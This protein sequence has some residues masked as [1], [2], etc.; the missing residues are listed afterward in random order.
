MGIYT[1]A[2]YQ[3]HEGSNLVTE[4]IYDRF[5]FKIKENNDLYDTIGYSQCFGEYLQR[6]VTYEI[7]D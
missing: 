4:T 1:S 6:N 2:T 5:E 7:V 3:S